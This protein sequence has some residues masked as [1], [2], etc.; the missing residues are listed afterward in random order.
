M[1][2]EGGMKHWKVNGKKVLEVIIGSKTDRYAHDISGTV[3]KRNRKH[4]FFV[5]CCMW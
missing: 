2:K 3:R 5:F 4:I 1:G